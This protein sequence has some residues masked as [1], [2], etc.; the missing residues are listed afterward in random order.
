MRYQCQNCGAPIEGIICP[1]CHTRQAIDLKKTY[2]TKHDTERIC[3]NCELLLEIRLLDKYQKLYIEQCK[4]C[5]GIFL[6]FG[7]IEAIME[8]EIVKSERYDFV[9]LQEI[10]NHPLTRE[11]KVRYKK[12]PECQKMMLR[13]NYQSRSGVI[14]DRC[15]DHG[16]WLDSGELRQIMEWAKL[17]GTHDFRPTA[18][19]KEHFNTTQKAYANSQFATKKIE[20][21]FDMNIIENFFRKLYGFS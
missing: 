20:K 4:H 14:I 13:M 18:G 12:C 3:P 6:D 2:T 17:E 9:R 21:S 16:Y 19:K 11:K 5:D 1:Y 10:K 7:E 15:V 8:Q